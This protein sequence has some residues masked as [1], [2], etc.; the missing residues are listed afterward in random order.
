MSAAMEGK[1]V[2]A[3]E[4][5]VTVAAFE[6]FDAGVFAVMSRQFVRASE[7]PCAVIPRA[8][9]WLFT[10]VCASVGFKVRAFGVNLIAALKLTPVNAS[11]L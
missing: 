7:L 10:C 8:L 6:R 11:P 2:R 1:V 5:A 3:G 9:I 4:T